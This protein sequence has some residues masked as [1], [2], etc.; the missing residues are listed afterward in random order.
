MNELA[1]VTAILFLFY[2]LIVLYC[3][4]RLLLIYC[5]IKRMLRRSQRD[6]AEGRLHSHDHVKKLWNDQ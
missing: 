6:I 3:T 5:H 4:F 2:V 1:T